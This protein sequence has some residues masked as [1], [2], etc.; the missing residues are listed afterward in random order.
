[1]RD[2][3]GGIPENVRPRLF[4]P[5]RSSKAGGTGLGLAISHLLAREIGAELAL[6]QTGPAGTTF[7][8][9]LPRRP[10]R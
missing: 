6:V 2:A 9:S 10:V 1:V 7:S 3:G 8:V 4:L 5:G